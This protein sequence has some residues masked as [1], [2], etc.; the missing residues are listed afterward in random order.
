MKLEVYEQI[1]LKL[2]T[3]SDI[4]A[5]SLEFPDVQFETVRSI[6]SQLHQQNIA[7]L[8]K[9]YQRAYRTSV[10][11]ERFD[12]G[13]SIVSM[14]AK[15]SFSPLLL[16]RYMLSHSYRL[17]ST[18]LRSCLHDCQQQQ[19]E[20]RRQSIACIGEGKERTKRLAS[21]LKKK[22]EED[23][24]EI[25]DKIEQKDF[26][27]DKNKRDNICNNVKKSDLVST[28][29]S[30]SALSILTKKRSDLDSYVHRRWIK[31]LILCI[32]EEPH[33]S[34]FGNKL[35]H[36]LG[37]E[38]EL[39]LED[40]VKKLHIPYATEDMLKTQGVAKTPDILL[41][42]PI[43]VDGRIVNW[44]D[45]KAMFGDPATHSTHFK[46]TRGYVNRFGSGLVIYWFDFVDSLNVDSE[47]YLMNRFP[48]E[49]SIDFLSTDEDEK[50]KG[51]NEKSVKKDIQ[52]NCSL[53]FPS[54]SSSLSSFSSSSSSSSLPCSSSFSALT[55]SS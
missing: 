13:E 15:I 17:N 22:K 20:I 5:V 28:D 32:E 23:R 14:A 8:C 7:K 36:L 41:R 6:F 54:S 25:V 21:Q 2:K 35:R 40:C 1:K 46:Q 29:A 51:E 43:A 3:R 24:K 19:Q 12:S 18:E 47:V 26:E 27:S 10:F 48:E 9:Y 49:A 16:A 45:S 38:F 37:H 34:P 39:K 42:V 11:V 53:V 55:V 44:I 33:F 4:A 30:R 50:E 52:C 31:E